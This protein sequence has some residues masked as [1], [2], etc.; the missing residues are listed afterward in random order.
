MESNGDRMSRTIYKY[1]LPDGLEITILM[2]QHAQLLY[3][4]ED[5]SLVVCVWAEINPNELL[6]KRSLFVAMTGHMIPPHVTLTKYVGSCVLK[7]EPI[8]LHLYDQGEV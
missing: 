7:S 5:P 6:V 4:A 3:I 2:P 1:P 8:V